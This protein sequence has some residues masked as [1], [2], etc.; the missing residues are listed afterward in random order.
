[1]KHTFLRFFVLTLVLAALVPLAAWA[2]DDGDLRFKKTVSFKLDKELSLDAEVGPMSVDSVEF[3]NRGAG[4]TKSKVFSAL[5]R[6]GSS[7]TTVTLRCAFDVENPKKDE[8]EL[9]ATLEFFDKKGEL[10]DR[11]R[12]SR[13]FEGE[14][15]TWTIDHPILAY[16]IP[17]IDE[18]EIQLQAEFD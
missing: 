15:D 9:T 10:I 17:L 6:S 3:I 2:D 8:W 16:V 7:D 18:V 4:T 1:M 13:D 12:S 5:R 11:V 14:A